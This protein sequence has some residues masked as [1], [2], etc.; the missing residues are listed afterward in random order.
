MAEL[1]R[2][3]YKKGE[4]IFRKGDYE[5]CMYQIVQGKVSVIIHLGQEDE[6]ELMQFGTDAFL[7]EMNL[8]E[9]SPRSVSAVALEDETMLAVID[10]ETFGRYFKKEP[11]K[12]K[13][14]MR[15]LGGRIRSMS[16]DY[17]DACRALEESLETESSGKEMSNWIKRQ[18]KK[19]RDAYVRD[20]YG[21]NYAYSDSSYR[22]NGKSGSAASHT[23]VNTITLKK[24]GIVFRQG[25]P[26]DCM[27]DIL[28]GKVGVYEQYGTDQEKRLATLDTEKFFGEMGMIEE[29]PR[30][31]T[32]VALEKDTRLRVITPETFDSYFKDSP[33]KILM[34]MQ[35]MSSL[36]RELTKEYMD[37][38]RRVA[39]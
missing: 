25:E 20:I 6:R 11:E 18:L 13:A 16:R 28:W 3:V 38:C 5:P 2:K 15:H 9:A 14:V 4:V 30:S 17:M 10:G 19:L 12:V 27:Y 21:N 26:S 24:G 32:A 35:G 37:I 7:G 29:S 23:S 36:L 8:L 34:I 39:G 33:A 22:A 1:E 31:V